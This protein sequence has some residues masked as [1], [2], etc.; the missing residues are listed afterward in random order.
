[1]EVCVKLEE[2]IYKNQIL[3]YFLQNMKLFC[4]DDIHM[5]QKIFDKFLRNMTT[6]HINTYTQRMERIFNFFGL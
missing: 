2:K 5:Y 3:Q 6:H 4:F 1:M